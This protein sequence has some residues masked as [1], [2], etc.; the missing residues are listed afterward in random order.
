MNWIPDSTGRFSQRPIYEPAELDY[1]AEQMVDGFLKQKYGEV[2]FPI[3]TDD[4]C[5]MIEQECSDLDLYADLSPEGVDVEG[6]TEFFRDTKPAV[7]ISKNVSLGAGTD[8]NLRITLAHEY[9]HVRF[10]SFLWELEPPKPLLHMDLSKLD[11][12]RRKIHRFR[13]GLNT[14]IRQPESGTR[15]PIRLGG[16][17]SSRT[18]FLCKRGRIVDAPEA[19]WM[20]WQAGYISGAILMPFRRLGALFQTFCNGQVKPDEAKAHGI[21]SSVSEFFDVSQDASRTRLQ[22]LGLIPGA[23]QPEDEPAMYRS[24]V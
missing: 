6:M 18:A 7:K 24:P 16:A 3:S 5:V 11:I 19:D 15:S 20:E 17:A 12:Q 9:G 4:L 22:K 8:D 13:A 14:A 23:A 2:R 10:H 21:V 1:A